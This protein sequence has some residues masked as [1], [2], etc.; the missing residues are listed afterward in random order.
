M[1]ATNV[2]T[3]R[4]DPKSKISVSL[5]DSNLIPNTNNPILKQ[6]QNLHPQKRSFRLLITRLA[7]PYQSLI[8]LILIFNTSIRPDIRQRTSRRPAPEQELRRSRFRVV[9][10]TICNSSSSARNVKAWLNTPAACYSLPTVFVESGW[11]LDV[12]VCAKAAC[13]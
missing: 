4:H 2:D 5:K 1:T 6:R 13:V 7:R 3:G 12:Y 10:R 9:I 11:A 8:R